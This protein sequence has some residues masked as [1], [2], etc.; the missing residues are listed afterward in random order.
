M[1]ICNECGA[2]LTRSVAYNGRWYLLPTKS[3]EPSSSPHSAED[4]RDMQRDF[5][6]VDHG[7]YDR[8]I[9]HECSAGLAPL[10]GCSWADESVG[11][12]VGNTPG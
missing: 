10:S 12:C 11:N 4:P 7:A 6:E 9:F 2:K 3:S 5:W 1:W 8:S